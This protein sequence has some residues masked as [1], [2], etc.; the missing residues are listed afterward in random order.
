[1]SLQV[2]YVATGNK[3][4]LRDFATAAATFTSS[5]SLNWKIGALPGL[6]GIPAPQETADTFHQNAC[7]K[8]LYYA[9]HASRSIV[10]ADDSGLVVDALRGAPGVY[11]ARFA[12]R[13][14][15]ESTTAR[16]PDQ[17]NNACLLAQLNPFA[18]S[19]ERAARYV[20]V[21]A[22]ARDGR[23]LVTSEGAVAGE[24]LYSERGDH[25]FGYDPL[26]LLPQLNKTMAE[27]DAETRLRLSHR[28]AA[29]RRLLPQ[30]DHFVVE[31]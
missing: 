31:G 19:E 1:M 10:I 29:L 27:L 18:R 24:I 16:T 9:Q 6:A 7:A 30:L 3:G 28:G 11:S 8:A 26:F 17:R 22:A 12:E 20:C 13:S 21:L 4:K 23:V 25:G 15:F 14:G 5:S 2:L